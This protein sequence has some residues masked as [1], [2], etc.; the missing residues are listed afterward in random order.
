MEFVHAWGSGR[1]LGRFLPEF[2]GCK[3]KSISKEGRLEKSKMMLITKDSDNHSR[4]L[5]RFKQVESSSQTL[6]S[7]EKTQRSGGY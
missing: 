2:E 3:I 5:Q 6:P 7:K 1:L 4:E